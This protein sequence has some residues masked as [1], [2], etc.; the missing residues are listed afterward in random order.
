MPPDRMR[1]IRNTKC[2]FALQ[3]LLKENTERMTQPL[4]LPLFETF[5][6]VK[7]IMRVTATMNSYDALL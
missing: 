6:F 2:N 4:P 5:K 3:D 1:V 7:I